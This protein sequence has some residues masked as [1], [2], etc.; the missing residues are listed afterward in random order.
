MVAFFRDFLADTWSFIRDIWH[1]S[2]FT[3]GG[4]EFTVKPVAL[5]L[6]AVWAL[7]LDWHGDLKALKVLRMVVWVAPTLI[8]LLTKCGANGTERQHDRPPDSDWQS[9]NTE[10]VT[11][12]HR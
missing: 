8:Y 1:F 3:F 9:E 2:L 4:V 11:R 12:C 10:A 5:I 6:L 7:K